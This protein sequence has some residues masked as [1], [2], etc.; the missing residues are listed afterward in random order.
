LR[1]YMA[2][3]LQLRIDEVVLNDYLLASIKQWERILLEDITIGST[4]SRQSKCTIA[5]ENYF[6]RIWHQNQ[7]GNQRY[8]YSDI[9]GEV[10]HYLEVTPSPNSP[11]LLLAY[12]QQ[13]KVLVSSSLI[14]QLQPS[15]N[16]KFIDV[17]SIRTLLGRFQCTGKVRNREVQ[18]TWFIDRHRIYK[19]MK[20]LSEYRNER[21][22]VTDDSGSDGGSDN[23]SNNDMNGNDYGDD[24]IRYVH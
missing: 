17:G 9:Y 6:V 11:P 7:N 16:R 20:A 8:T 15:G 2:N 4:S 24:V 10:H 3:N 19:M 21:I 5:R 1:T 14:E 12:I 23:G 13:Y 18:R 22:E